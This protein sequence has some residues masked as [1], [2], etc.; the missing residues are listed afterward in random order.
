M[1]RAPSGYSY[2]SGRLGEDAPI[3]MTPGARINRSLPPQK[4]G[5][6]AAGRD[7]PEFTPS[8]LRVSGNPRIGRLRPVPQTIEVSGG[9]NFRRVVQVPLLDRPLKSSSR[10]S[11]GSNGEQV[12]CRSRGALHVRAEQKLRTASRTLVRHLYKCLARAKAAW[13]SSP[14]HSGGIS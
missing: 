1:C 11:V 14:Y 13:E 3:T 12:E 7:G 10:M 5:P 4:L 2:G 8:G 9:R 6:K